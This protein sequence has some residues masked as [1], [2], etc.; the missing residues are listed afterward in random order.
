MA[1]PPEDREAWLAYARAKHEHEAEEKKN[2]SK[3][4]GV[5]HD[6]A[7]DE[8]LR[9]LRI[10]IGQLNAETQPENAAA[11]VDR[12]AACA[13][14][15]IM[16]G[17]LLKTVKAQTGTSVGSMR[18]HI[19][20]VAIA[21]RKKQTTS[22]E[23]WRDSL[24][25]DR[26]GQP[27]ATASNVLIAL[28]LAPQWGGVLALDEFHQRPMLVKKP[29][30]S[31]V[32]QQW[33]PIAFADADEARALVWIQQNGIPFCRIEAVR[34]ALAVAVDNNRF[35]PVLDYLESQRW[36]KK[37]RL[38]KLL[39]FYFGVDRIENY[40]ELVGICW[41]ISAVA[42]IYQPGCQAKYCLVLEGDQD[43]GKST[44]LEVLGGEWYTDDIAELGTKDSAMQAANAWIVELAELNSTRRAH[45]DAVKAFISRKVDRFRKPFGRH[46]TSQQRRAQR[47]RLQC[48]NP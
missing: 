7:A 29:P 20:R 8:K 48:S 5:D 17:A 9:Q 35:H 40:T 25:R 32:D 30:W 36:D 11:I 4:N 12:I 46:V 3:G 33:Q 18:A 34:Q 10:D 37:P 43:L 44:A 41:M 27:Y 13:T 21:A 47:S 39:T 14:D 38:H 28:T 42:R 31:S 19:E 2:R 16:R 6:Q 45:V 1:E 15:E 23:D 22:G 24:S 26:D